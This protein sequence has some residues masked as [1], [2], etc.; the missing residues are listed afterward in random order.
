VR[1]RQG[2]EAKTLG[3]KSR[4]QTVCLF[5]EFAHHRQ[6]GAGRTRPPDERREIE[7]RRRRREPEKET[8][9]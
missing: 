8:D 6:I 4:Q 1:R 2:R 5:E 7:E 9:D 3:A